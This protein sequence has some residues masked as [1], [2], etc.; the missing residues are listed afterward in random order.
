MAT[1]TKP[2]IG[3][4]LASRFD[5]RAGRYATLSFSGLT[6]LAR[7][8]DY[9]TITALTVPD[10]YMKDNPYRDVLKLARVRV[11]CVVNYTDWVNRRRR[12]EGLPADFVAKPRMW[13]ERLVEL[14]LVVHTNKQGET[15]LYLACF[16]LES[17]NVEYRAATGRT[18]DADKIRPYLKERRPTEV[19]L[20]DEVFYR[21]YRLDHVVSI[22]DGPNGYILAED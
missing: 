12:S 22:V 1:R 3:R 6:R 4:T 13:G 18:V 7:S 15:Y 21:E 16:V 5:K 14:P 9:L 10:M 20:S 19:G 17:I 8:T 2:T 11:E